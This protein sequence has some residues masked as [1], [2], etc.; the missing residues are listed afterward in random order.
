MARTFTSTTTARRSATVAGPVS[1]AA[2]PA[3]YKTKPAG[4]AWSAEKTFFDAGT[5]NSYPTLVEVAP[6]EFR[7][8]WDSGDAT[9]PR[10]HVLFGKFKFT[11]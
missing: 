6:G 3:R 9:T 10:T 11:P 5:K 1:T 4:G 2:A 8:V 7:A